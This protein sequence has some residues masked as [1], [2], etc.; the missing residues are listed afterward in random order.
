M[1][2]V[3]LV[4]ICCRWFSPQISRS[5]SFSPFSSRL[6]VTVPWHQVGITDHVEPAQFHV[7]FFQETVVA[8]PVGQQ[9]AHPAAAL[10]AVVVGSGQAGAFGGFLDVV[11]PDNGLLR[12]GVGVGK[13]PGGVA[14]ASPAVGCREK[15][16][17]IQ[18]A[19]KA[20]MSPWLIGPLTTGFSASPTC[21]SSHQRGLLPRISSPSTAS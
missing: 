7:H 17:P 20:V 13:A 4:V 6:P 21:T 1:V 2:A 14:A 9:V 18:P 16:P 12:P 15:C 3:P 5:T 19:T 11:N 8:H 10:A